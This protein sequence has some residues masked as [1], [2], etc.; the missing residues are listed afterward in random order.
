MKGQKSTLKL[1]SVFKFK[2]FIKYQNSQC[3]TYS[4]HI[5]QKI[6]QPTNEQFSHTFRVL[7]QCE[8][9]LLYSEKLCSVDV[10]SK[11]R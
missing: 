3:F 5:R 11:R 8:R 6:K 10:V 9:D 7:P 2:N 1:P 4:P